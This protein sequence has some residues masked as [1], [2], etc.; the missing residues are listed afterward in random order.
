[1]SVLVKYLF[2]NKIYLLVIFFT[3]IF[4]FYRGIVFLDPDFG[5]HL[6]VGK[7]ILTSGILKTDPFS[8][9]MPSFPFV[10][11][12]WLN[13]V[14]VAK[15]FPIVG[16][17][18]LSLLF[19]LLAVISIVITINRKL[20]SIHKAILFLFGISVFE[21]YFAVSPRVISWLFLSIILFLVL[22]KKT[23]QKYWWLSPLII[24]IWA[25]FHG[26]FILGVLILGTIF[27]VRTLSLRKFQILEFLAAAFGMVVTFINPY[28]SKLWW[29]VWLTVSDNSQRFR[30][31]EW[32]PTIFSLAQLPF[33]IIVLFSLSPV[34]F[35]R[36]WNKF[37]LDEKVLNVIF[38]IFLLTAV[39]NV[40]LWVIA[41]LPLI[42]KGF[43]FFEEDTKN[44]EFAPKRFLRISRYALLMLVLLVVFQF[45][46]STYY[47]LTYFNENIFYPNRAV[48]YLSENLPKGQIFSEY[49]W[50][51]YLT[52]RLPQKKIF[53]SGLM[54]VWKFSSPQAGES[55]DAMDDYMN[56]MSGKVPYQPLFTKFGID[57]VFLSKSPPK[58][59]LQAFILD[60]MPFLERFESTDVNFA[61]R[62][63]LMADGWVIIYQDNSSSI[64][65]K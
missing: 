45:S 3:S 10:D 33:T 31:A 23:W 16:W 34:F 63:E 65:Q 61:L 22:D 47:F 14:L 17:V 42:G 51:G 59:N 32:Q 28:G 36:Y 27:I 1:M 5:W 35:I 56:L 6:A 38:F 26:S 40:P 8:Y 50:G 58:S 7:I 62:K 9:T 2:K 30:I 53:V 19:T 11:H 20:P 39:R 29:M 13:N 37:S 48:H 55:S 25:N 18:G 60:K 4:L 52:W 24:L 15:L 54:P 57:T 41:V 46:R 12:E 49:N 64:Y 44:I 43:L 21:A